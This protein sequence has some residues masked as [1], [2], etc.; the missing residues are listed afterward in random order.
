MDFRRYALYGLL[1]L[2]AATA[3]AQTSLRPEA[4]VVLLRNGQV[5]S[6][7]VTRAG[8]YYIVKLR[9]TGEVR[10]PAADVEAL[11]GSLDEVYEFK[12]LHLAGS[13]VKPHLA[14]AEWCLRQN[15]P[16]RCSQ[17]LVLAMRIDPDNEQLKH[18][19]RRLELQLA[20][21]PP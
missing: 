1:V 12:S 13:G 8:D 18:L 2:F 21:P 11:C 4:G 19:E 15:L 6:G 9:E 10:L 14:L 16:A 17:Q 20:A 5:L 3:A 7:L